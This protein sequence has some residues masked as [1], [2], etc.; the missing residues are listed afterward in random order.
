MNT[1]D[2]VDALTQQLDSIARAVMAMNQRLK[3]LEHLKQPFMTR[4]WRNIRALYKSAME[5]ER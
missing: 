1:K 3:Q 4:L 5:N 2:K